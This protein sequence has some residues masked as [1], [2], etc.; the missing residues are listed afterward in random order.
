[1]EKFEVCLLIYSLIAFISYIA[2][3]WIKF[4]VLSAISDS[5][6]SLSNASKSMF[7]FFIWSV[8]IPM[9]IVGVSETGLMFFA[10]AFLS[11]VG[12]APAF[13]EELEGKVHVA[14]AISGI[15]FGVLAMIFV[16]Q[17]YVLASILVVFIILVNLLKMKN[18]TWWIEVLAFVFIYISLILHKI[19][20]Y[21]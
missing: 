7:T 11:F 4:G 5:Y 19:S 8:S 3:I 13:K 2:F 10:G 21:F 14:G 16:F 20:I 6:Y 12:A 18:K 15:G 17:H 9:I 1:M